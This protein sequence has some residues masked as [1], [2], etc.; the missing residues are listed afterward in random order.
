MKPILHACIFLLSILILGCNSK[1]E[2]IQESADATFAALEE[3]FLDGYWKQ[4]PSAAIF[5][6]Y[7]KYYES[8][9]VP[10]S[11]SIANNITFSRRWLD[12]LASVNYEGL[13]D[14]NKI[15]FNIIKN[16]LESD[17]W[18]TDVFKKDEWDASIYNLSWG[19]YYII[20]QPYAPL[21]DR[22]RIL[23]KH[24]ESGAAYYQAAFKM[25]RRP[26]REHVELAILQ[27][28]GGISVF[29]KALTDSIKV[30]GLSDAEKTVLNE[31]ISTTVQATKNFIASLKKI[32]SD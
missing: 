13:S 14:N 7:G 26:I 23:S 19:C 9:V 4:Y 32:L 20:N 11:I 28:E 27:N 17:I 15:S 31:N 25:L 29:G 8:P 12:S 3:T 2:P 24:L 5:I 30:S 16:Q 6:G 18:Y 22:L 10:D 1:K 21:D